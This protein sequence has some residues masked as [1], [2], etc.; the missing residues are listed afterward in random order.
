MPQAVLSIKP[1]GKQCTKGAGKSC[2]CEAMGVREECRVITTWAFSSARS[3][4]V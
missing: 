1:T 4:D 3:V 2:E